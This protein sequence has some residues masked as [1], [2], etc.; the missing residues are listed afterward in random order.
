MNPVFTKSKMLIAAV[1]VALVIGPAAP[2]GRPQEAEAIFGI[3]DTVVEVG[4]NLYANLAEKIKDFS[5]DPLV[6]AAAAAVIRQLFNSINNW[7]RNGFRGQPLFV[8]DF[9]GFLAKAGDEAFGIY[10]D[11]LIREG[12]PDICAPFRLDTI[13][14]L[15]SAMRPTPRCTLSRVIS[16]VNSLYNRFDTYGWTGYASI[17]TSNVANNAFGS[18]LIQM[19]QASLAAL[20]KT[21]GLEREALSSKGFLSWKECLEDYIDDFSQEKKCLKSRTVTPGSYVAEKLNLPDSYVATNAAV[22]DEIGEMISVIASQLI[23]MGLDA[24]RPQGV[25]GGRELPPSNF[26]SLVVAS[27]IEIAS[28]FRANIFNPEKQ[29]FDAK[30]SS[31]NAVSETIQALEELAR[32]QTQSQETAIIQ[33]RQLLNQTRGE[34]ALS[35]LRLRRYESILR[36]IETTLDPGE[37]S[38]L[39][40]ETILLQDGARNGAEVETAQTQL[41]DLRARLDTTLAELR[42]CEN[43][44]PFVTMSSSPSAISIGRSAV[45][46]WSSINVSSCNAS[47][48]WTGSRPVIGDQTVSPLIT[49]TYRLACTGVSG[50]YTATTTVNV[51]P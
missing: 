4:V 41:T 20:Q 19:D 6:D 37:L 33:N 45:I 31:A 39:G 18:L 14:G 25:L 16:N 46:S 12:A 49:S 10:M 30:Q 43:G 24:T 23:N 35:E 13:L 1:L 40:R 21:T 38:D 11:K 17:S 28:S 7:V 48:A 51:T 2:F 27:R 44:R 5:L 22:A 36:A 42:A 47:G 15:T 8:T 26:S 50:T 3:G 29:Y 32:C 9:E 34:V